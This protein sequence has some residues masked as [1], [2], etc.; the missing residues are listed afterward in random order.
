M[1]EDDKNLL[2]CA[3]KIR[4]ILGD[5]PLTEIEWNE[6]RGRYDMRAG[7]IW[8]DLIMQGYDLYN[9]LVELVARLEPRE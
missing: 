2:R 7:W 4:S 5:P 3:K 8:M 1:N 6:E 9:T